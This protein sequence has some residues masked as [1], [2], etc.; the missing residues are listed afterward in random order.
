LSHDRA[1]AIN[2]D[3][4]RHPDNPGLPLQVTLDLVRDFAHRSSRSARRS[5]YRLA[6][7]T[8]GRREDH[9]AWRKIQT[10][11]VNRRMMRS[12]ASCSAGSRSGD[13]QDE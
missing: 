7:R 8:V 10:N 6:A 3:S 5:E 11:D 13:S 1:V 12:Q 4:Q 9:H 2:N